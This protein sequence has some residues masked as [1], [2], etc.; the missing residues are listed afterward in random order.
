MVRHAQTFMPCTVTPVEQLRQLQMTSDVRLHFAESQ[1]EN[2]RRAG[3][4]YFPCG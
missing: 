3:G 4:T 2:N 1:P